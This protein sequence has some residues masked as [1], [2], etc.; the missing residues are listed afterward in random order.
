[1]R[2]LLLLALLFLAAGAVCAD[3]KSTYDNTGNSYHYW[4]EGEKLKLAR[5]IDQGITFGSPETF[6]S[7]TSEVATVD[8]KIF[9]Y[10]T[11]YL[12]LGISTEAYFTYTNNRGK[13]FSPLVKITSEAAVWPAI[14]L[15]DLGNTCFLYVTNDKISGLKKLFFTTAPSAESAL[16][17]DSQNE[18]VETGI[19]TT[20]TAVIALWREKQT[21]K[22]KTLLSASLDRGKHF[23]PVREAPD[24]LKFSPLP[25]PE[26]I[27]P[28]DK[29]VTNASSI[30][31][32]FN[33]QTTGPLLITLEVAG[34]ADFPANKTWTLNFLSL[35]GSN[36]TSY[37]LPLDLPN[38]TY[39]VRLAIN[40]GLSSSVF[41]LSK[42]FT[43]DRTPPQLVI[44]APTSEA[45]EQGTILIKGK[46]DAPASLSINAKQVSLEANNGFNVEQVLA[47]GQNVLTFFASD[48]A[49]NT[50]RTLK[51]IYFDPSKP[52]LT[53]LKPKS[54]DWFKPGSIAIIEA[55]VSDILDDI[56]DETEG[57]IIIAGQTL[58]DKLV[59]DKAAKNLSGF[60]KLPLELKDGTQSAEIRLADSAG[61]IGKKKFTINLDRQPPILTLAPGKAALVNSS[62]VINLPL[63]DKGAGIDR[64]GTLIKINGLSIEAAVETS[65][66]QLSIKPLFPLPD[67]TYEVQI[68]PRDLVGNSGEQ[69][70]FSLII[71]S[72]PPAPT[73]EAG[74]Y[75]IAA[76]NLVNK[77]GNGPN[78]FSPTRDG[79]MY[80][81]YDLSAAA[82]LKVYIFDLAGTLIW[83]KSI[84]SATTGNLAWN[85]SDQFGSLA[86][87]GVYPYII[88]VSSGGAVEVKRGKIIILL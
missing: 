48:E 61:N 12:A 17:F 74:T 32:G 45:S 71:D 66:G 56:D 72:R 15:D 62:V 58:T 49:G 10:S 70:T 46:L 60:V 21:G 5:S 8:L 79:Q 41:S 29:S 25:I 57:D 13:S 44:L 53:V 65:E 18:L 73:A 55:T 43:I 40:D 28:L 78:P 23:G 76:A 39:F 20:P 64:M 67:G 30:E 85:G 84:N 4:L 16:L 14:G 86:P 88:Q 24:N 27:F 59:Y 36:E 87:N 35:P 52:Q 51:T 7:F 26:I 42:Q 68:V 9:S 37:R 33:R 63:I 22:V 54:T 82:D 77:F 38:G 34:A 81:T 47:P 11:A 1:M 83:K 69:L 2:K 19:S 3:V 6:T 31:V 80:F 75:A 50:T